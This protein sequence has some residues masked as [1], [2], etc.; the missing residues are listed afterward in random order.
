MPVL[1]DTALALDEAVRLAAMAFLR[2]EA[3]HTGGPVSS[4]RLREFT[5]E[6]QRIPLVNQTGIWKP[7]LLDAALTIRTKFEPDLS[8]RPYHDEPGADG[9]MRY[10][11]RG[12]DGN[13]SDNRALRTAMQ[14][15]SPLFVVSPGP[16]RAHR[17]SPYPK[18]C[19]ERPTRGYERDRDVQTPSR[20]LR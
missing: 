11:W 17:C 4:I 10:K 16:C 14:R 1:P 19:R 9:L 6:G 18:R 20:H 15:S 7:G 12:T 3:L 13:I 2:A 5:Y 8:K